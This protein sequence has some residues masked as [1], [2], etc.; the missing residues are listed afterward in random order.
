MARCYVVL[1]TLVLWLML[2]ASTDADVC[3][4]Q[5]SGARYTL[6]STELYFTSQHCTLGCCTQNIFHGSIQHNRINNIVLMQIIAHCYYMIH[7]VTLHTILWCYVVVVYG[8][9]MHGEVLLFKAHHNTTLIRG[10]T[11]LGAAHY[12]PNQYWWTCTA[13]HRTTLSTT[14]TRHPAERQHTHGLAS[15]VLNDPACYC[16]TESCLVL[17]RTACMIF[18]FAE[19]EISIAQ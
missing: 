13:S 17:H 14:V 2:M 9:T 8:N 15:T 3:N 18:C 12:R 7:G 5:H 10:E 19:R 16:T 6:H 11:L 4:A 1:V